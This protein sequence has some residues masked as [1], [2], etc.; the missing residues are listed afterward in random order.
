MRSPLLTTLLL[1]TTLAASVSAQEARPSNVRKGF[2]IGFGLG[3]GVN[4]SQGLDNK[5][6]WG[7]NGYIRLGGTTKPDILLGGEAIGWTVDDRGNTLERGN[8]HFVVM[9]YPNVKKGFYLK[10]GIGVASIGES[11]SA[12]N[13]TTTTT[14]GGFGSGAGLGYELQIGKNLYLVPSAD[15][16]LQV[17]SSENDPVLGNIPGTNTM[18]L[19]NL[20]LTWH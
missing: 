7:G 10:G 8:A 2:W 18:L 6:L 19:F 17:F 15:F 11:R 1:A 9:W 20:G 16:L 4:L 14:K 5:S 3:G 12:G 13:T